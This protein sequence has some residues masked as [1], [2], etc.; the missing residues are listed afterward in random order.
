MT[1]DGF[2][3]IGVVGQA[4]RILVRREQ[5]RPVDPEAGEKFPQ[6]RFENNDEI[7]LQ[8]NGENNFAR[9]VGGGKGPVVQPSPHLE[10]LMS[11]PLHRWEPPCIDR[12]D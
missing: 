12:I 9:V 10:L 3:K 2:T 7:R 8:E 11:I 5:F 6:I 4:W 1:Y